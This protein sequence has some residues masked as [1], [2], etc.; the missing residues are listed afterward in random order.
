[1]FRLSTLFLCMT[2]LYRLLPAQENSTDSIAWSTSLDD[3][4]VTAQYAPT[5]SR[6]AIHSVRAI[7]QESIR[8]RGVNSLDELLSQELNI[9]LTQDLILGSVMSMQGISGQNVKIMVDGVP[10]VGRVGDNIDLS[11][12]NLSQIE[13]VEIVEGPLSVN[14]GSDALGGVINLITRKSQLKW[15]DAG[16]GGHFE[17]SGW[18]NWNAFAGVKILP[19]ILFRTHVGSSIF[20]GI[21]ADTTREQLWNAKQNYFA[22]SFVRFTWGRDHSLRYGF[23]WFDEKVEDFGAIRRPQFKPYAFD[24]YYLTR[25]TSHHLL[26]EGTLGRQW[27]LQTTVGYNCYQRRKNAFRLDMESNQKYRI[28]GQQDTIEYTGLVIRPVLASKFSEGKI[29]FQVGLDFNAETAGGTRIAAVDDKSA[30]VESMDGAVF[31]S[32]QFD[33]NKKLSLQAGIR[34]ILHA[35][36]RAPIV[37]SVHLRWSLSEK[38]SL[39]ASYARGFR[40]PSLKERYF[41]FVDVNHFILGNPDL[42]AEYSDHVQAALQIEKTSPS[43]S[44]DA[45]LTFF[46]N[47]IRNKIDLYSFGQEAGKLQYAYFNRAVYKTLGA[48]LRTGISHRH[49]TARLGV[50]PTG[51][52]N[53][54]SESNSNVRPYTYATEWNGEISWKWPSQNLTI[55]S[56]ARYNDRLIRFFETPNDTGEHEISERVEQGFAMIDCTVS[57][58]IF[59]KKVQLV[60]GARNLLNVR[61]IGAEGYDGG[62]GPHAGTG[63]SL[64]VSPGRSVFV[65]LQ[66]QW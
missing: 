30:R 43:A 25:R 40:S 10:V 13:R 20:N 55:S 34:G 39:R 12:I 7:K 28:A 33:P 22:N 8:Q 54:L 2:L 45:T 1:M 58:S 63:D 48:S 47:D 42:E 24:D 21:H 14:Y 5:D 38:V 53:I 9:R 60:G 31:G 66:V 49:W 44:G 17:S 46:F 35:T 57:K 52:Y 32:L 61:S 62:V 29:N 41:Y 26:Q 65:R 23:D 11:Q 64:P 3:V 59:K 15:F 37:P 27:Y 4:V 16:A 19:K 6:N 36:Y 50:A 56:Y 18:R 51:R